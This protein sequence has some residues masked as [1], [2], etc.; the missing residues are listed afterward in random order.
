MKPRALAWLILVVGMI[1]CRAAFVEDVFLN[2]DE[3]EYAVAADGLGH[4]WLPG[5]DLLGSTKP[6]GIVLLYKL[7]F[8]LFGRSIAVVHAAHIVI[9]IAAGVLL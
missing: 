3:A 2:I 6:P 5:V 8:L 7:L 1:W 4:G 9:L